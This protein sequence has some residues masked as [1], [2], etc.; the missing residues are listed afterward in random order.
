MKEE[1]I[2]F[3]EGWEVLRRME[4]LWCFREIGKFK[5]KLILEM[6]VL[7]LVMFIDVEFGNDGIT[8]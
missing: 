6:I 8:V 1:L 5:E 2:G 4:E 7:F 3:I